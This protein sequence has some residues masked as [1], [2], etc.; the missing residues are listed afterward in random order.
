MNADTPGSFGGPAQA[1][2]AIDAFAATGVRFLRAH[3]P[4]AICQPS[5]SA[6]LTGRWPHRNGAEGFGPIRDDVPVLTDLLRPAGYRAGILGKVEHLEPI[7]RFS[8]DLAVA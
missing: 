3:V 1:T 4:V 2:P 5:R 7:E 6:M 8:W